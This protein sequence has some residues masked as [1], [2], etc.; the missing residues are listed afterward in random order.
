MRPSLRSR[1]GYALLP[2]LLALGVASVYA[3]VLA[4]Y[5]FL[6]LA[7]VRREALESCTEQVVQSARAW[8]QAHAEEL[9]PPVELPIAAMLP[10]GTSGHLVV[11]REGGGGGPAIAVCRINLQSGGQRVSLELELLYPAGGPTADARR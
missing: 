10:G 1:R 2:A 9:G 3:V 6:D 4:R 8:V 11:A 5:A 7:Q